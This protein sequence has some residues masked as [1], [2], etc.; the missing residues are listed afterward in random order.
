MV[1][2]VVSLRATQVR[3]LERRQLLVCHGKECCLKAD[4]D[5]RVHRLVAQPPGFGE[6]F[7]QADDA[8]EGVD[9]GE[10]LARRAGDQQAAV[11]GAQIQRGIG[12]AAMWLPLTG[13]AAM[14]RALARGFLVGRRGALVAEISYFAGRLALVRA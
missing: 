1:A 12:L 10:I 8:A 4:R 5:R 2:R 14:R 11:V 13:I 9:D 6:A 3:K 7:A